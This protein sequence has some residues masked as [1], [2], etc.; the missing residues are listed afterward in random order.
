MADDDVLIVEYQGPSGTV[1]ID[2]VPYPRFE[3]R[4]MTKATLQRLKDTGI[5]ADH[6]FLVHGTRTK[7]RQ[8]DPPGS[9]RTESERLAAHHGEPAA[10]GGV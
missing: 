10:P 1:I 5:H 8:A 7:T 4:E 2:D 6:P 9:S 3:R